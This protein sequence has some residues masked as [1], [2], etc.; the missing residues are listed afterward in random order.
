MHFL[1]TSYG[2]FTGLVDFSHWCGCI[3]RC[4]Q[5]TKLPCLVSSSTQNFICV[6]YVFLLYKMYLLPPCI[7][8]IQICYLT[9]SDLFP[10]YPI[11]Q[12]TDKDRGKLILC[13]IAAPYPLFCIEENEKH[14][15]AIS[16]KNSENR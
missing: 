1:F 4:L 2:N 5:A 15:Q 8:L 6:L 13:T 3:I 9:F 14:H 11:Q 12:R 7:Y 16:H 10:P